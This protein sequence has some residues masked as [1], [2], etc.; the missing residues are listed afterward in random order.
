MKP[1]S[2]VPGVSQYNACFLSRAIWCRY[3]PARPRGAFFLLRPPSPDRRGLST[4]AG[5]S[6]D[7]SSSS[8][9][10]LRGNRVV[11]EAEGTNRLCFAGLRAGARPHGRAR[12]F[13]VRA[14]CAPTAC[15]FSSAQARHA[16]VLFLHRS[17]PVAVVP[18]AGQTTIPRFVSRVW[19]PLFVRASDRRAILCRGAT[20]SACRPGPCLW[21]KSRISALL[22]SIFCAPSNV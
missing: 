6:R 1:G 5:V 22:L 17:R 3:A 21:V 2:I 16:F 18:A 7:S 8:P 15:V 10:M 19:V 4:C 11:R 12:V 9:E 14:S 13:L 20:M